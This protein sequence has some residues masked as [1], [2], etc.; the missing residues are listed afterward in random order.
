MRNVKW[1]IRGSRT[2]A[3]PA[4]DG[5][6][7]TG[8]DALPLTALKAQLHSSR[9]RSQVALPPPTEIEIKRPRALPGQSKSPD[10]RRSHATVQRSQRIPGRD[11]ALIASECKWR[12]HCYHS[13]PV[14]RAEQPLI[15]RRRRGDEALTILTNAPT[16]RFNASTPSTLPSRDEIRGRN[17][18]RFWGS[19]HFLCAAGDAGRATVSVSVSFDRIGLIFIFH[20]PRCSRGESDK[21]CPTL[22]IFFIRELRGLTRI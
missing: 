10:R 12:C 14:Q 20:A 17:S 13:P 1:E 7:F 16:L 6:R 18:T 15:S 4:A 21:C 11:R 19:F 9:G 5:H 8:R 2:G 3:P 22:E